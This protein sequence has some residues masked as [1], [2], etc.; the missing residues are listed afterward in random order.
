MLYRTDFGK[1]VDEVLRRYPLLSKHYDDMSGQICVPLK[2]VE[3]N[4]K[5]SVTLRKEIL[6]LLKEE[7]IV[8]DKCVD[9]NWCL[10]ISK[11]VTPEGDVT[12]DD[13]IYLRMVDSFC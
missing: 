8:D 11:W 7:P 4:A 3:K 9:N 2:D 13:A 12:D 6:E 1:R 5:T 10:E